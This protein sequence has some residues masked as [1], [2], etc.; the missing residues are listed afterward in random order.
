MSL[1]SF[2]NYSRM[3]LWSKIK[4]GFVVLAFS[5]AMFFFVLPMIGQYEANSVVVSTVKYSFNDTTVSVQFGYGAWAEVISTSVTFQRGLDVPVGVYIAPHATNA[6]AFNIIH[7]TVVDFPIQ[8]PPWPFSSLNA[9]SAFV[10]ENQTVRQFRFEGNF[11][12]SIGSV[13]TVKFEVITHA[14]NTTDIHPL[15][16]EASQ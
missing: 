2:E 9:S 7:S 13:Y 4:V 8:F 12:V 3:D 10:L 5:S 6:T 16:I 14:D 1:F 11:I 15:S